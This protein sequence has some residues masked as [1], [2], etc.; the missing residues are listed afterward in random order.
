MELGLIG[1]GRMGGNVVRR[2]LGGS[3]RVV[4]CDPSAADLQACVHAGATSVASPPDLIRALTPPRV[5]W[6]ILPGGQATDEMIDAVLPRLA[7][8]DILADAGNAHFKDT[9]RRAGA[10]KNRG[11]A[12]LDAGISGGIWGLTAG[13]CLMIGGDRAAF[14]RI[15]PLLATLAPE[16]GYLHT[17]GSGS[18]HFTKMV[19]NGIEYGMMQAYA[20]GFEILKMSDFN[21]DLSTIARLWNHGSVIRSWLLELTQRA[22]ERD[23]GLEHI[24]GFV[25]DSGE[26]RW[27]VHQAIDSDVS[28]PVVTLSLLQRLR[29]RQ[30]DTFADRLLAAMRREFGG[31]PVKER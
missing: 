16:N 3:H 9:V 2:L 28:A 25:E 4:V 29:S 30:E 24:R 22:L 11:I 5:V 1:L 14:D 31:H 20:E 7:P 6:M 10:V 8:G 18:G 13:Y 23:P 19:H 27:T 21:L 17:G 26:G 12:Y 15:E